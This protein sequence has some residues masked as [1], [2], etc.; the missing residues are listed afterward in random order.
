MPLPPPRLRINHAAAL[1]QAAVA[2]YGI[3]LQAAVTLDTDLAAGRLCRVLPDHAPEPRPLTLVRLPD[4]RMTA[5]LR[6]FVDM[7]VA[8]FSDE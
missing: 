3:I 6:A 1:R 2:G 7:A 4:R 5:G 8:A